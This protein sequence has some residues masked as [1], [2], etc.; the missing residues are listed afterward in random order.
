VTGPGRRAA[1][2]ENVTGALLDPHRRRSELIND[3]LA[4][5]G[6]GARPGTIVP[7]AF[8]TRPSILRRLA[9]LLAEDLPVGLDRLGAADEAGLALTTAL[10]LH[11]GLPYAVLAEE[12]KDVVGE[13]HRGERLA[14]IDAVTTTGA[15][16]LRA[17]RLADSLG[18]RITGVHTVLEQTVLEH[19]EL[20]KSDT[21]RSALGDAGYPLHA[22]FTSAELADAAEE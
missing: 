17:A 7:D 16:A 1:A 15:R 4:A 20:E 9:A 6:D 11:T 14:V 18:V 8:V 5:A 10:A 21:A 12:G 22:L 19:A 13:I 3:L 2:A